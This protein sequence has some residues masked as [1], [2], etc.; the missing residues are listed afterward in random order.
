MRTL[1]YARYSSQLQNSRSIEDQI[2][3]C[4]ERAEQEGWT[5]IDVISDAAIG[6]AA[7]TSE[8]QRPGMNA[9]LARVE[10]GGID[11][12]L[13]DTIRQLQRL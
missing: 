7:G 13:S 11:Q 9:L 3:V 5:V 10:A 8:R 1:I 2:R 6:G 4:M 12:V